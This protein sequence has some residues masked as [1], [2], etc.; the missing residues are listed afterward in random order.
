MASEP[1][2][3]GQLLALPFRGCG[4]LDYCRAEISLPLIS[5]LF[6]AGAYFAPPLMLDVAMLVA[7]ASQHVRC[8]SY[9]TDVG[10]RHVTRIDQCKELVFWI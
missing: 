5:L 9:P 4:G 3:P 10:L 2:S 8:T 7:I 1:G 6:L